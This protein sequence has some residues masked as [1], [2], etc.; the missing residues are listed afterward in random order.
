MDSM[1][2][3]ITEYRD[4]LKQIDKGKNE[5]NGF[6]TMQHLANLLI[7]AQEIYA[8]AA[9]SNDS[10]T[11]SLA[12]SVLEKLAVLIVSMD[13]MGPHPKFEKRMAEFELAAV[14]S[15]TRSYKMCG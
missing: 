12:G 14:L 6:S 15:A 13:K 2:N 10:C 5:L 9:K 4:C 7:I 3:L 1:Q 11:L 8:E